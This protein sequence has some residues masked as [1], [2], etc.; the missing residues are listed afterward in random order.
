MT[1]EQMIL[2]VN[3][4]IAALDKAFLKMKQSGDAS[5]AAEL[6]AAVDALKGGVVADGSDLSN[7]FS[8]IQTVQSN[9]SV[10]DDTFASDVELNDRVR[11]ATEA[12]DLIDTNF[13]TT[14]QNSPTKIEMQAAVAQL[15]SDTLDYANLGLEKV[16]RVTQASFENSTNPPLTTYIEGLAT[17]QTFTVGA[18]QDIIVHLT[19]DTPDCTMTVTPAAIV[20]WPTA[21]TGT[22][23]TTHELVLPNVPGI[24]EIQLSFKDIDG[25]EKF[26]YRLALMVDAA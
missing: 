24:Y 9:L 15:A 3:A 26:M 17:V 4:Y 2:L 11:V 22:T 23:Q 10:L 5:L 16:A 7:L 25:N 19:A 18:T 20:G 12:F 13:L 8:Q 21:F 1:L 6:Q 14:L